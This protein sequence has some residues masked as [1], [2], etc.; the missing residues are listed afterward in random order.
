MYEEDKGE[1]DGSDLVAL[2][3]RV[4]L[5]VFVLGQQ[6]AQRDEGLSHVSLRK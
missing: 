6:I 3:R 2:G 4:A 1:V 5:I